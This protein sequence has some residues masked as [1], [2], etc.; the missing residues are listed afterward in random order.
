MAYSLKENQI[1]LGITVI[2]GLY[3]F[4][5]LPFKSFLITCICATVLYI[6]TQSMF[7]LAFIFCIPQLIHLSNTLIHGKEGMTNSQKDI[8]QRIES[9]N[10]KFNHETPTQETFTN[11]TEVSERVSQLKKHGVPNS[12]T[13]TIEGNFSQ[14]GFMREEFMGTQLHAKNRIETV[15]EEDI[16]VIGTV[17]KNPRPNHVVEPFDDESVNTALLRNAS[18][19]PVSSNMKSVDMT[20]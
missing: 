5:T 6:T 15:P 14:S 3:D 12:N 7:I 4:V 9:M 13:D 17:E 11:A 16:P 20:M 19:N 2:L 10:R 8:T 18:R 1:L